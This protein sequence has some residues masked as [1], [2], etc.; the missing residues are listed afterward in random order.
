PRHETEDAE[1]IRDLIRQRFGLAVTVLGAY[2]GHYTDAEHDEPAFIFALETHSMDGADGALPDDSRW[3]GAADLTNLALADDEQ[4]VALVRWFAEA[5]SGSIPPERAPWE[6]PG[7]FVVATAWIEQELAGLGWRRT[8][9]YLQL[10]ARGWSS[11]LRLPTTGGNLYFKAVTQP[12]AF[13][14]PLTALLAELR[15]AESPR[16]LAVDRDR[17]WLLMSDAG[18]PIRARLRETRNPRPYQDM[19]VAFAQF[20]LALLPYTPRLESSAIPDRRLNVL[21]AL[22][23][24]TLRDSDGLLVGRPGGL[25]TDEYAQLQKM[26]VAELASRLASYGIPETLVQE[27]CHPGHWI[28]GENGP[29]FFD[30]GDTCLGHPFQSLMMALRWARLVLGYDA[31]TLDG[32]RDA[33]LSQWSAYG[34]LERLRAAYKLAWRLTPLT[35]AL[36]WYRIVANQEPSVRWQDE[37]AAPYWLSLF[38]HGEDKDG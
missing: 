7:W 36:T 26:D 6:R 15:P 4:R 11:V 23:A 10:H 25:S 1:A 28:V 32:L 16:V 30:W 17:R 37:D 29:I 5:K 9:P 31:A 33:Y 20:Q 13:E 21:P 27:D 24:A 3:I 14:P 34:S 18:E 35:R 2:A 8:G 19:L 22:F 38:L 12:F